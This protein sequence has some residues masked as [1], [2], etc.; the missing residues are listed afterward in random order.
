MHSLQLCEEKLQAQDGFKPGAQGSTESAFF[1][2]FKT[3]LA[4][5]TVTES[6]IDKK[7][8]GCWI[9]QLPEISSEQYAVIL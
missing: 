3:Q 2:V 4:K 1:E 9:K 6:H 8:A 5:V 7:E